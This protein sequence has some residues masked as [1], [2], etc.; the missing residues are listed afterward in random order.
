MSELKFAGRNWDARNWTREQK[1]QWQ[2]KTFELGYSWYG[3]GVHYLDSPYYTTNKDGSLYRSD[4]SY[5]FSESS[6]ELLTFGDMFPEEEEDERSF[7]GLIYECPD[8]KYLDYWYIPLKDLSEDQIEFLSGYFTTDGRFTFNNLEDILMY[9]KG[10]FDGEVIW[11]NHYS[12]TGSNRLHK[13]SFNDLF[14][15][16]DE[17]CLVQ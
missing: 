3:E 12:R 13:V 17:P 5:H 14:K 2:E 7:E 1:I 15:Y 6:G 16:E 8:I 10:N 11:T 4:V 9:Q